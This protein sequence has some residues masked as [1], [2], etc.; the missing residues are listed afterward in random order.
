[1]EAIVFFK[2]STTSAL[3]QKTDGISSRG[4]HTPHSSSEKKESVGLGGGSVTG[5]KKKKPIKKA[6]NV[7]PSHL[8]AVD[9]NCACAGATTG[10]TSSV[11]GH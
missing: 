5:E 7:N 10:F 2:S 4:R 1:M 11:S 8:L 6:A 9:L 3:F